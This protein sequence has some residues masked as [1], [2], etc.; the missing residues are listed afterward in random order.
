VRGVWAGMMRTTAGL[1]D[2]WWITPPEGIRITV[3]SASA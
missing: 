2:E 3:P 1:E